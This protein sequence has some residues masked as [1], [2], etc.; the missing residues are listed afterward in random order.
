MN[1]KRY[2]AQRALATGIGLVI[3]G[4]VFAFKF[5]Q[6]SAGYG[7][8]AFGCILLLIGIFLSKKK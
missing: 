8:A 4:P 2:W 6:K 3:V 1:I 5:G 7:L